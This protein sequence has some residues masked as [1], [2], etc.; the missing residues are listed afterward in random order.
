MNV[1][2]IYAT[3]TEGEHASAIIMLPDVFGQTDYAKATADALAKRFARPVF[4]LDYFYELT[5]VPNV[6]AQ[7]KFDDIRPIMEQ[8]TGQHFVEIW[9]QM[10]GEITKAHPA[11]EHFGVIGFCFGGRLTYLAALDPKVDHLMSFYGAGANNPFYKGKTSIEALI[12]ARRDDKN[13]HVISFYGTQDESIPP[14][15]RAATEQAL[16]EAEID[17]Q[18]REYD[19]GHAYFQAG[20]PS[21]DQAAAEKSW[22]DLETFL[23]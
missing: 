7:D 12:E 23:R 10:M 21:H 6:F 1:P 20:R 11:I 4:L 9:G 18:A 15:D 8:M 13:L 14:E 5:G 3:N 17:Y 2:Y 19:A 16:T 22:A